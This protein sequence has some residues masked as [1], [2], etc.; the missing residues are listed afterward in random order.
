M[1]QQA[2]YKRISDGFIFVGKRH[3][4][5]IRSLLEQGITILR[6]EFIPGFVTD[7][8]EFVDRQEAYK[9]AVSCGQIKDTASDGARVLFSEDLY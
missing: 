6:K 7:T 4:D 5:V 9:I 2:A 1:I 8:G 3:G